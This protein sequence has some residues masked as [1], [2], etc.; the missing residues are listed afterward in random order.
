MVCFIQNWSFTFTLNKTTLEL[1]YGSN[2]NPIFLIF[3]YFGIPILP[4]YLMKKEQ[5]LISKSKKLHI[6]QA[7]KIP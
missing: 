6:F 3:E 7:W 4:K 2:S 1:K 5:S